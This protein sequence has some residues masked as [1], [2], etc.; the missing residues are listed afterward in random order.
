M[1]KPSWAVDGLITHG[2]THD[3]HSCPGLNRGP[4][5]MAAKN[6]HVGQNRGGIDGGDDC[7]FPDQVANTVGIGIE[8]PIHPVEN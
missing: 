1:V 4:T 7:D 5:L 2:M 6:Q 8:G 3:G